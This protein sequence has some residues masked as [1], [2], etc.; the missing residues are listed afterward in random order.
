[1]E[2]TYWKYLQNKTVD[3]YIEYKRHRAIIRKMKRRQKTDDWNKFMK[4]LES[5]ITG[6]QRQG[7]KIFKL[8][9]LQERDKLKI[10]QK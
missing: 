1:M 6:T 8:P 4:T 3:Y 2:A 9:Y 7:F 10:E 5:N